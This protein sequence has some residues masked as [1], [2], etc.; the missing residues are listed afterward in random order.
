AEELA[1]FREAKRQLG[2]AGREADDY[3]TRLIEAGEAPFRCRSGSRYLYVDEH[4]DVSWGAQTRGQ[5]TKAVL[6]YTRDDLRRQLVTPKGCNT[7]CT[8][9]CARTA[10]AY[11]AWRP[12][13]GD[14]EAASAAL[15]AAD[16]RSSG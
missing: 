7:S 11:D 3:R 9:G 6:G 10:S 16:V 2:R 4:G 15:P 1:A 12:Q 5:V 8:V 13:R 14:G